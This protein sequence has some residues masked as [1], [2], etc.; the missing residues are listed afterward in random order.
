M[1]VVLYGAT[2]A[3]GVAALV[4]LGP[5]V[6]A[7]LVVNIVASAVAMLFI[8]WFVGR[9]P[10]RF[11]FDRARPVLR[12]AAPIAVLLIGINLLPNV[13]LWTLSAVGSHVP[14]AVIGYYVAA[15]SIARIPNFVAHA[16]NAALVTAIASALGA[17]DRP[18]VQRALQGAT[19][20]L[21]ITL[22]PAGALLAVNAREVLTLLYSA[23]YAP[24]APL[25]AILGFGQGVFI[26]MFTT[27]VSIMT[28]GGQETAASRLSLAVLSL[29]VVATFVLATQIGAPGA[30]L[31]SLISCAAAV[32]GAGV[33]LRREYGP[34]LGPGTLV[35]VVL[36]TAALSAASAM[37]DTNGPLLLV[38]LV[39]LGLAYLATLPLLGLADRTD[40]ELLWPQVH[41]SRSG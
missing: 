18:A 15:L 37:I 14:D 33:L 31:G 32:A 10:W 24:A 12:L 40:L 13:D 2:K 26:T 34:L 21:M 6:A 11:S 41:E 23:D 3:I 9:A 30:A 29:A 38:E 8:A 36:A 25:L 28:G 16:M 22:F 35:R 1:S 20:F 7:A 27:L 39:V 4:A 19:R 5:T 17:G